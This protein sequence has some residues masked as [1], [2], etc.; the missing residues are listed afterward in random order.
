MSVALP[1]EEV[2]F[3]NNAVIM[4]KALH[5]GLNKLKQEGYDVDV[6]IIA[7][8]SALIEGFQPQV[9]INGF[10]TNAH[11][12]WDKIHERNDDFFIHNASSI[13]EYLP[14]DSVNVFK[15]L[16]L[17]KNAKGESVISK[18]LKD[19]IWD[20]FDAMIKISIK[21]IHK[22]RKMVN[23][24]YTQEFFQVVPLDHHINVWKVKL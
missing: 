1:P 9:L 22:H 7:M 5:T 2:R 14:T 13:F 20:L 11:L 24:V 19:E 8:A 15:D 21:Y 10:I 3:K 17:T 6:G 4:T 16:Y 18:K 23:G 12:F